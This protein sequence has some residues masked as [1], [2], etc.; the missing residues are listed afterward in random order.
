M[1]QHLEQISGG[2]R[3]LKEPLTSGDHQ[4]QSSTGMRTCGPDLLSL[5]HSHCS[6][7]STSITYITYINATYIVLFLI[8][9][10]EEEASSGLWLCF[11][12]SFLGPIPKGV[13]VIYPV[14][15]WPVAAVALWESDHSFFPSH[16]LFNFQAAYGPLNCQLFGLSFYDDLL[17]FL[18][19]FPFLHNGRWQSL[20]EGLNHC[21]FFFRRDFFY[22]S[23][24]SY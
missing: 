13:V 9:Y 22:F 17:F 16:S 3:P 6:C 8:A 2:K 4:S 10:R 5:R 20:G 14:V 15:L 21:Y 23:Y 18:L 7:N 19:S 1:S 24:Q 12:I 11:A